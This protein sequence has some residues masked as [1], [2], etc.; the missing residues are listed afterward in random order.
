MRFYLLLL[1][2]LT[3]E[4]AHAFGP[5][6]FRFSTKPGPYTVGFRV[7]YQYDNSRTY[8][9][10][11]DVNGTLA[12]KSG[13]RPLQTLIWY[14]AHLAPRASA[15]T[16]GDYLSLFVSE[17]SFTLTS[18]EAASVL[19]KNLHDYQVDADPQARMRAIKDAPTQRGKF[20]LVIYAPSFSGPAFENADICEYLASYGY[21]V[22]ASPS[23]GADSFDMTGGIPGAETQ[24]KDIS[25][26]I[27]FSSSIPEVDSS[28][29]AVLGYSWGGLSNFFAA[30]KDDR[31]KALL[32]FDGSARYFPSLLSKSGYV[33]PKDMTI[34]MLFFTRGEIPLEELVGADVSAS[35]LN[36]MAHSDV[37]IVRMHN[38]RHGEFD[39]M[40]QRSPAYWTRHPSAEYSPEETSESY[41]WV[42]RY[43]LAFLDWTFRQDQHA[44]QFLTN[45]PAANGVPGHMLAV[46]FNPKKE[47]QPSTQKP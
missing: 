2:L 24:A 7:A 14:P 23:I 35:V 25:F 15:M 44:H 5:S 16:Y 19:K 45:S 38:M 31:I 36:E 20:P 30:A 37:Y 39:S 21:I 18:S 9:A 17:D 6:S 13:A 41:N 28:H 40:K 34:P 3:T 1:Y 46:Q 43:T 42:G 12:N 26:E 27:G 10:L 11:T 47:D 22:M 33:Q 8:N 4:L 32:A 29:I